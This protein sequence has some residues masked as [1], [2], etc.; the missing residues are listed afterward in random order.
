VKLRWPR[1]AIVVVALLANRCGGS[2]PTA[3]SPAPAV[4]SV[5]VSG[6]LAPLSV[7]QAVQLTATAIASNGSSRVVTTEAAWTSSNSAVALVSPVGL[8]MAQGVGT[9]EIRASYQGQTGGLALGVQGPEPPIGPIAGLVCGTERWSVKTLSDGDASRV[10]LSRVQ[11]T[12]IRDLTAR[13]AHCDGGPDRRTYPEEFEVFEVAGR[14][15]FVNFETDRDYHVVLAD[16]SDP[17]STMVTEVADFACQ[18]AI[19]SPHRSVIETTRSA[20]IALL[21]GRSPSSLV[22]ATVRLR[23]VGFFD[24]AHGQTGRSRNCI[25][26]HPIVKIELTQ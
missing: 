22:G 16:P 20:F 11:S 19:S 8:V 9:V 7:G 10:D 3:P 2:Q 12:T 15:T 5:V 4:T 21:A 13:A 17:N 14:V 25:E 1:V 24:F 26:L 6:W 18:G 23:G